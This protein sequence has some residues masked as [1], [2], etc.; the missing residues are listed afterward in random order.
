MSGKDFATIL[1]LVQD[2]SK[3]YSKNVDDI[4]AKLRELADAE[5]DAANNASN[6][7]DYE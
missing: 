2:K 4:I 3:T 5:E 6:R 7:L 1:E